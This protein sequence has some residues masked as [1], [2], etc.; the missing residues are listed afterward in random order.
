VSLNTMATTLLALGLGIEERW[1]AQRGDGRR[2]RKR[3]EKPTS[4]LA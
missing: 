4:G 3:I 1:L 2:R